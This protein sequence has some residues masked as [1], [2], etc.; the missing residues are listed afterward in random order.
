MCLWAVWYTG[1]FLK[2][3]RCDI[4]FSNAALPL[5]GQKQAMIYCCTTTTKRVPRQVWRQG[6]LQ[7]SD[8]RGRIWTNLLSRLRAVKQKS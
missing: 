7:N 6:W 8:S 2:T 5:Y 4:K 1:S 3:F